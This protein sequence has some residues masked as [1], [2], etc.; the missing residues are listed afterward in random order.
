MDVKTIV[1]AFLGDNAAMLA[2]ER[3]VLSRTSTASQ[4]KDATAAPV[5]AHRQRRTSSA[6]APS[7][8]DPPN[9]ALLSFISAL[10]F[11]ASLG[12]L[13]TRR[14]ALEALCKIALEVESARLH[15]YEFLQCMAADEA[16]ADL[17]DSFTQILDSVFSARERWVN[18]AQD[19][20]ASENLDKE[21]LQIKT[22]L[23]L[24]FRMTVPISI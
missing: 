16:V 8:F 17:A 6:A 24:L 1:C 18:S 7:I 5:A 2:G 13:V 12:C 4:L 3:R 11:S 15:V 14:R 21:S 10:E 19:K 9:P 22:R 23:G 20:K